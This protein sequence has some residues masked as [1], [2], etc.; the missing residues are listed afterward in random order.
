MSFFE[1]Q[2]L[3]NYRINKI[4]PI[5]EIQ[6]TLYEVEHLPTGANLLHLA[7]DEQ[8]NVFCLAFQTIPNNSTGVAHI[9][10][11]TVLCG[12][13]DYPVKDPFFG[14]TR[15]SLNTFMNALTGSDFTCYPAASLVEKDF[16]HLLDVYCDAVFYP[17]LNPLSFHQEG[18]RLEFEDKTDS[19]S[20]L[21]YRGIVYNEMKGSMAS[22]DSRLWQSMSESLMPDLPYRHNSGGDPKE[23]PNLTYKEFKEFYEKHYHPSQCL[24]YFFGNIG[25]NKHLEF[26]EK[27]VFSHTHGKI[28]REK[29]SVQKRFSSPK[30]VRGSYPLSEKNQKNKTAVAFSWLTTSIQSRRDLLAIELLDSLLFS[31]DASVLKKALLKTKLCRQ[32][33][34]M[35]DHEI[36]EN[37]F[38]IMCKGSEPEHAHILEK[39]LFDTL[40]NVAKTG[41]EEKVIQGALHQLELEGTEITGDYYPFGL[42]LFFKSALPMLH[43]CDPAKT[44]LIHSQYES[45]LEA[46]KDKN[47]LPSLI[48]KYFLDNQHFVTTILTP[49]P[50]LEEKE[51]HEEKEKLVRIKKDL[52]EEEKKDLIKK[53]LDLET[54]QLKQEGMDLEC[55]PK[56]KVEDIPKK[57]KTFKLEKT[58]LGTHHF[59]HH[60]C[61]TNHFVYVDLIFSLPALT[62]NE[63]Y[64][65]RLFSLLLSEMGTK[66]HPYHDQ[67]ERMHL[68]TGGIGSALGIHSQCGNHEI[69]K[70]AIHLRGKS[71]SRNSSFLFSMMIE[72]MEHIDFTDKARVKEVILD[73]FSQMEQKFS[74]GSLSY[75]TDLAVANNSTPTH[76]FHLWYGYAFYQFMENL[77]RDIDLKLSAITA[78]LTS[79]VHK[80]FHNNSIDVVITSSEEDYNIIKENNFY[81]LTNLHKHPFTAW[82]N[83][84]VIQ[85]IP[86]GMKKISS[87]VAFTV[88]GGKTIAAKELD[89]PYLSLAAHLMQHKT[90]HKK[91]R[92][93]GG[94][95]GAGCSYNIINGNFTL[96][97]YRDPHISSTLEA[98]KEAILMVSSEDFD[99]KDLEEAKFSLIQNMDAPVNPGARAADSYSQIRE[100]LQEELRQRYRDLILN[101]KPIDIAKA[102][103]KH[104]SDFFDRAKIITFCSEALMNKEKK[105]LPE[106]LNELNL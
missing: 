58:T 44:L 75:A 90:L 49:D 33:E 21:V 5:L 23:I 57:I 17:L 40:E 15:R 36:S 6:A 95:Y 97:S 62:S 67:L 50:S 8:E 72:M 84:I 98:F 38:Y 45:L 18:C 93:Q 43:G 68:Y 63:L 25:L 16:Y 52:S 4:T 48:K 42:T 55:L 47:Y 101:A 56:L 27:K 20:P 80:L 82:K 106:S 88:A 99:E 60:S 105:K 3:G 69:I 70:P 14:M 22:L 51:L 104:L 46:L 37:P 73:R 7:S 54:F 64:Y 31:H 61:F 30:V 92:E 39:T 89:S 11:H 12:S 100:N 1:K 83:E 26:L 85:P 78:E 9:L 59:F 29:I 96:Y 24:F 65:T 74:K 13:K 41:F 86:S 34:S 87:P 35:V 79:L 71:L 66:K 10:E 81:G 28:N 103:G 2:V 53:A 91:I 77:T 32:V 102:A 94:A 76:L 19:T